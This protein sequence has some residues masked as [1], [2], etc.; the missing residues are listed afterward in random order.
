MQC[1]GYDVEF[2]REVAAKFPN[3]VYVPEKKGKKKG[4][5]NTKGAKKVNSR[6]LV[7]KET[8]SPAKLNGGRKR[9]HASLEDEEAMSESEDDEDGDWA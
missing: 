5:K 2:Q 7:K 4:K 3:F 8:A 6:K 1:V 9:K